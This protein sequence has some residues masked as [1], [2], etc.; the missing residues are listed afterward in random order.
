MKS[1]VCTTFGQRIRFAREQRQMDIDELSCKARIAWSVLVDIES[2]RFFPGM[3]QIE[4]LLS[5]LEI[6]WQELNGE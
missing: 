3:G 5:A 2:G 4:R 6:S 1:I